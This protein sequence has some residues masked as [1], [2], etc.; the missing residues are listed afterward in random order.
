MLLFLSSFVCFHFFVIMRLNLR[1]ALFSEWWTRIDEV[2]VVS[3]VGFYF[4]LFN[5]IP[6]DAFGLLIPFQFVYL[7]NEFIA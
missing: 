2:S 3:L 6:I 1:K 7:L 4:S 5:F